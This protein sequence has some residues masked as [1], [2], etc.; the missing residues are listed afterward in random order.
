MFRNQIIL[1]PSHQVSFESPLDKLMEDVGC[2]QVMDICTWKI[3]REGLS[4]KKYLVKQWGVFKHI[5]R[6]HRQV[7][8][9][10]IIHPV[11]ASRPGHLNAPDSVEKRQWCQDVW[12]VPYI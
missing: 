3:V 11:L 9:R 6:H 8:I 10:P 2:Q 7:R 5:P 12:L 1:N 4:A